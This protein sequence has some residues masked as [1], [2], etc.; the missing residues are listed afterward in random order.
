MARVPN[1]RQIGQ[2]RHNKHI[3]TQ[4]RSEGSVPK[5]NTLS[6]ADDWR[7]FSRGTPPNRFFSL[8]FH[9]FPIERVPQRPPRHYLSARTCSCNRRSSACDTATPRRVPVDQ[10]YVKGQS[11]K[12]YKCIHGGDMPRVTCFFH[13]LL[14]QLCRG[15]PGAIIVLWVLW[16][17]DFEMDRK[18]SLSL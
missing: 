5:S 1:N 9:G 4:L 10:P 12:Q 13:A 7:A 16:G 11:C 18:G 14:F 17:P 15:N 2:T 6:K 8:L 3:P